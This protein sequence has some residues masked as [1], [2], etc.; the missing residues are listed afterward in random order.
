M[1]EDTTYP[2]NDMN[3]ELLREVRSIVEADMSLWSMIGALSSI[4]FA[5]LAE[6]ERALW[7]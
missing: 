1:D 2:M 4:D 7:L 5:S 3:E 6:G